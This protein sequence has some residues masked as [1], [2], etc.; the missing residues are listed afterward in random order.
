M[1]SIFAAA[2]AILRKTKDDPS[3]HRLIK[4]LGEIPEVH[5]GSTSAF[6]HFYQS[7]IEIVFV[8]SPARVFMVTFSAGDNHL[9]GDG[10]YK[11]YSGDFPSSITVDD[12][13]EQV[14]N[15]LAAIPIF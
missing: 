6:Y 15:K 11:T 8:G 2:K 10:P 13:S 7:G 14:R 3:F 9:L 12:S 1:P 5:S 4:L